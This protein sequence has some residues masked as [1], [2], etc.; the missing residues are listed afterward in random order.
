MKTNDLVVLLEGPFAGDVARVLRVDGDFVTVTRGHRMGTT[1]VHVSK[2]R[3]PLPEGTRVK[4]GSTTGTVAHPEAKINSLIRRTRDDLAVCERVRPDSDPDM[5][6]LWHSARVKV[7][8]P[9]PAPAPSQ[10]PVGALVRYTAEDGN[11][12]GNVGR[13]M[14]E[15][16]SDGYV[17]VLFPEKLS[18]RHN[19]HW[20]IN[21]RNLERVYLLTHAELETVEAG[22]SG[23][24]RT[25]ASDRAKAILGKY[26]RPTVTRTFTVTVE[27]PSH[28]PV[29]NPTALKA[30]L[31]SPATLHDDNTVTIT[32]EKN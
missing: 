28:R 8:E 24:N 30:A 15:V 12:H 14:Q 32:E 23:F 20:T 7:I 19:G 10:L 22:Y 5:V 9:A 18:G 3:V 31:T 29:I 25:S 27:Q 21:L 4:I 26:L 11:L 2:L 16:G 6:S 13:V 1:P 17:D